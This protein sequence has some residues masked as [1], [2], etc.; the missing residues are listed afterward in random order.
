MPPRR[1]VLRINQEHTIKELRREIQR[2]QVRL[3]ATEV[4]QQGEP[5]NGTK[6]QHLEEAD[7]NP[8]YCEKLSGEDDIPLKYL[9]REPIRPLPD[10]GI[11]IDLPEFEGL[12]DP[13]E[14]L[15]WLHTIEK[16]LEYKEVP[17]ECI[18]KF[19]AIK[20]K[21]NASLWWE[22]LKRS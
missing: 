7:E 4:S 18:I 21:G 11:Q 2:F 20:L 19:V 8:F 12:L 3:A 17:Q 1:G 6:K 9:R 5:H 22:N 15:N 13:D 14:S 10:F 16:I